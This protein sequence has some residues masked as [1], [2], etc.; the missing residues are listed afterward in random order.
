MLGLL[1]DAV[2]FLIEQLYGAKHCHHYRFK[3]HKPEEAKEPPLNPHGTAR[4]EVHLRQVMPLVA[5]G[6]TQ[7]V[8]AG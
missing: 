4:A 7:K 6:R 2:V 8:P 5:P 1:H 3:F